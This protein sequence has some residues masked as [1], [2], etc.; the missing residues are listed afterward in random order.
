MRQLQKI[1]VGHDFRPGGGAALQSAITLAER[2][3]A[4]IK[5]VHVVD[6]SLFSKPLLSRAH[7]PPVE[8]LLQ[9]AQR[10]LTE[11]QEQAP[12]PRVEQE[13]RIGKPFVELIAAC[14][15][16]QADLLVV[17][18]SAV[19]D[20]S[21]LGSTSERVV[22]KAPVP[23]LV[24]KGVLTPE[25]H[26]FLI[27]VDFSDCASKAAE[28]GIH[29]ASA[30]GGEILF[31]HA[32]DLHAAY[33]EAYGLEQLWLPP[34]DA[35]AFPSEGEWQGFLAQLHMPNAISW[36]HRDEEGRAASTIVRIAKED[37]TDLIVMGTHGHTGI[38][39]MLIGSVA[40]YVARNA[41]C[42]VLTIRPDTLAF[43]LP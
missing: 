10:K 32:L 27:P 25:I 41:S 29:L 9:R 18:P 43:E 1:L 6:P 17:G 28:E 42:S 24:A 16:W 20:D 38:A 11:I 7:I 26:K 21:F 14:R 36:A 23:V 15:E 8:E 35:E 4:T 40:E 39:H 13:G 22:R 33:P 5:L 3:N 37:T 30:F 2:S 19:L 31:L 34:V 12:L